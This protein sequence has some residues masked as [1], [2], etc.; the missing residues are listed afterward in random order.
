[1]ILDAI[2]GPASRRSHVYDYTYL[3]SVCGG[4]YCAPRTVVRRRSLNLGVRHHRAM[5]TSRAPSSLQLP[6]FWSAQVAVFCS[7]TLRSDFPR[8]CFCLASFAFCIG[9][10][11]CLAP[12][13]HES[14]GLLSSFCHASRLG[15]VGL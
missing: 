2:H 1:M 11:S 8:I 15:R 12:W 13:P 3:R 9:A 14:F 7:A 5:K 6:Q 10:R 4:G